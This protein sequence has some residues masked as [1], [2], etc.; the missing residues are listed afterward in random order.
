MQM[1]T[2]HTAPYVVVP[3]SPVLG[4]EIVGVDLANG[5]DEAT[6]AALREDFW[7]YKVRCSA[8][9]ICPPMHM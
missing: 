4:A 6:A 9:S 7:R 2:T 5:V 1:T 3:A 8:I